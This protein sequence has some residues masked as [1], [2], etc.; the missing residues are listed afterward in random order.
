LRFSIQWKELHPDWEY[1][2]WRDPDIPPLINDHIYNQVSMLSQKC[3]VLKYELVSRFGGVYIDMDFEPLQSLEPMLDGVPCF[4]ATENRR[5]ESVGIFGA[6][7]GDKFWSRVVES[8][9]Q[10]YDPKLPPNQSTG[11]GI[12][13]RTLANLCN[14]IYIFDKVAFYPVSWE[15]RADQD[16]YRQAREDPRVVAIHHWAHSWEGWKE[17]EI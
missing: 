1:C 10:T 16:L 13:T 7:A 12:A 17:E 8:L 15:E 5:S 11:P 3:D 4:A 14:K 2:L 6:C 9:G